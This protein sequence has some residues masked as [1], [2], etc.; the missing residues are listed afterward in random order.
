MA[1]RRSPKCRGFHRANLDRAAQLVDYQSRQSIAF[2]VFRNNQKRT[3]A[4]GRLLKDR[5]Q[6]AHRRNLLFVQEN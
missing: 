3:A 6:I 1:F 5:Q 2:D 4:A